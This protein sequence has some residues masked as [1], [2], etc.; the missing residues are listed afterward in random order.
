MPIDDHDDAAQR[1]A[2]ILQSQNREPH[3][4]GI[5]PSQAVLPQGNAA[6]KWLAKSVPEG[7]AFGYEVQG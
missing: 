3:R 1:P 6:D 5:Q 7:V 2:M 4:P